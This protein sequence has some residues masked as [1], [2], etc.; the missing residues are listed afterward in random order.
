MKRHQARTVRFEAADEGGGRPAAAREGV[1]SLELGLE[2]LDLLLVVL[3]V[4]AFVSFV[5]ALVTSSKPAFRLVS[6]WLY[7]ASLCLVQK[8]LKGKVMIV[9]ALMA[10]IFMLNETV[11][12]RLAFH[13]ETLIPVFFST[14]PLFLACILCSNRLEEAEADLENARVKYKKLSSDLSD[15]KKRMEQLEKEEDGAETEGSSEAVEQKKKL[16]RALGYSYERL[17]RLRLKK[18]VAPA[19]AEIME[20]AFRRSAG[21][22]IECPE[23]KIREYRLRRYWGLPSNP[24]TRELLALFKD[25]TFVRAAAEKRAILSMEEIKKDINM[26]EEYEK[27]A[28]ELFP[29]EYVIPVTSS[30]R[31]IFV[32]VVGPGKDASESTFSPVNM[33][34]MLSTLGLLLTKILS[35]DSRASFSTVL[36]G[37]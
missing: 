20:E 5:T 22:V 13:G 30:D 28:G 16:I 31:C 9:T 18:D 4:A 35:R 10:F 11:R 36:E 12:Y 33:A 14:L 21:V 3:A 7:L 37:D 15:L 29:I 2:W 32:L 26:L 19:L 8:H 24:G 1:F 34:P 17:M 25:A 6:C 27:F 23:E